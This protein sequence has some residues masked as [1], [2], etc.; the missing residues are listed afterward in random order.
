MAAVNEPT[1]VLGAAE[2]KFLAPVKT[3]ETVIFEAAIISGNGK[4][5]TVEVIG[6]VEEARVFEGTFTAFV[7]PCHVLG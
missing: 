4:K 5:R 6:R 3:G 7:P 2:V 1:V